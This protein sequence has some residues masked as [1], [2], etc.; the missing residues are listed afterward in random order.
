M[1]VDN[2]LLTVDVLSVV[3]HVE[4][5]LAYT[6]RNQLPGHTTYPVITTFPQQEEGIM[7]RF[8]ARQKDKNPLYNIVC[9]L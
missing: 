8:W 3:V 7:R 9:K 5:E 4:N 1:I 2:V 6:V